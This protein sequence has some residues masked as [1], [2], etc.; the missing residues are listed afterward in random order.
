MAPGRLPLSAVL[1]GPRSRTSRDVGGGGSGVDTWFRCP[2][3][4]RERRV[5]VL[6]ATAM[7]AAARCRR[8]GVKWDR[9][10]I[11][12]ESRSA[13]DAEWQCV[14]L[15]RMRD[16]PGRRPV[17]RGPGGRGLERP[18]CGPQAGPSAP[19]LSM[20]HL[21][22]YGSL[23]VM[24]PQV[25]AANIAVGV[26]LL[27]VG[28]AD[29]GGPPHTPPTGTLRTPRS[30]REGKHLGRDAHGAAPPLRGAP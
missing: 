7:S 3:V 15:R 2:C 19:Q 22:C 29:F 30:K 11:P 14:T 9:R 27:T 25:I 28:R 20:S 24:S 10:S 12:Q 6:A 16:E 5:A 13:L 18:P 26:G 17:L 23:L 8:L 21:C 1:R 4:R